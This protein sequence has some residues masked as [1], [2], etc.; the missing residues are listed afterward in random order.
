MAHDHEINQRA[1]PKAG[2]TNRCPNC[3]AS[4]ALMKRWPQTDGIWQVSCS[5]CGHM[6]QERTRRS[7]IDTI[8]ESRQRA[9]AVM[10][11]LLVIAC[12]A[13]FASYIAWLFLRAADIGRPGTEAL[14]L[15]FIAALVFIVGA[16]YLWRHSI[17]S[18]PALRE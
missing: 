10:A 2:S 14:A 6:W 4:R 18:D 12:V 7:L 5:S 15:V 16:A 11:L 1:L 8:L 17:N 9:I 3:A 13:A